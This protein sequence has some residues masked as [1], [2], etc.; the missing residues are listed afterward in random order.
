M[1]LYLH[2]WNA[3]D[4]DWDTRNV[5]IVSDSQE[6]MDDS[7]VRMRVFGS[8]PYKDVPRKPHTGELKYEIIELVPG[9][10]LY[11]QGYDRASLVYQ[12]MV[13]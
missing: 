4:D 3:P 9:L 12:D 11:A 8:G 7:D 10:E 5:G 1:K 6:P 13:K 2:I